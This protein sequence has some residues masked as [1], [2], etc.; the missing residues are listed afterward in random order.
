MNLRFVC[1]PP[2]YRNSGSLQ[3]SYAQLY[4][5]GWGCFS[6]PIIFIK[7]TFCGQ[8]TIFNSSGYKGGAV[9]YV[10]HDRWIF[11]LIAFLHFP[12]LF[13]IYFFAKRKIF[14]LYM[15]VFAL[16]V[17]KW[18]LELSY[19]WFDPRDLPLIYVVFSVR[20]SLS[21]LMYFKHHL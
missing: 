17:C 21:A 18:F 15:F 9:L 7:L 4:I 11:C 3:E 13:L 10:L 1:F 19:G 5:L 14:R 12:L 8:N 20:R 2:H 16:V 6:P